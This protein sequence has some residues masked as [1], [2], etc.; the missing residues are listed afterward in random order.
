MIRRGLLQNITSNEIKS[1]TELNVATGQI[2]TPEF[3]SYSRKPLIY[4]ERASIRSIT[5]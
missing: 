3:D 1:F 2:G 5:S 4:M